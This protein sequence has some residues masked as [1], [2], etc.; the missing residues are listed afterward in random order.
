MLRQ[1]LWKLLLSL[2]IF[3]WAVAELIP[4]KDRP[5][6]QY[7]QSQ[8]QAYPVEFASLMKAAQAREKDQ[9]VQSVFV[10]LKELANEGKVDLSRFFPQIRLEASLKN[11]VKRNS[12]L[13]DELLRRSKGRLQLG[14]DL[15]GGVAFTLEVAPKSLADVPQAERQAKLTKAIEI[16][17]ARI[18]SLGVAEPIVRPVGNNR[19]EVQLP[20]VSTKDNP[21]IVSSLKKPARLDFRLV[22]TGGTPETIPPSDAPPGFEP[23]TL[24]Q[25]DN[26]GEIHT[27]ELYVKRIPEMTGSALSQAFASMDEFGRFK[28]LL[29]FTKEGGQRFAAVTRAIAE[30][31]Q[32]TGRIGQLAIVLDGKLYSAPTVREEIPSGSAEITGTFTQREAVELANVLNNPL[33]LPLDIKEQYEVGPSLAQDAI[34][35]GVKAAIIGT[36]LVAA[37]M[38]SYYTIGGLIASIAVSINVLIIMGTLASLG[39]TLSMPGIAGIV[40]TI[41]MAVDAHILIFERIR[42]E[43]ALGKSLKAALHAGHDKAFTTIVDAN[44][45]TMISSAL[46][47]ALGTG[48]VKG[49]GVTLTIGIFSTMFTALVVSR[50]LLEF[51]IEPE[52]I[53][54]FPM[55]SILRA[56][57]IDFVKYGKV[58]F[59]SSWLIVLVGVAS[60]VV[61]YKHIYGID[62]VG[63]DDATLTFVQRV[64]PERIRSALGAAKLG[65]VN[66]LYQSDL[67]GDH[68][69]LTVQTETGRGAEAVAVL[70]QAF[71]QAKFDA[72]GQTTIG[73]SIGKEI[74]W[75]AFMSLALSIVGI[76]IYVAFRFEI[77]Y[78]MGAVVSTVHDVLMTIGIFV[79]TGRQ[80]TAPMV[81]AILLIVGYSINDTIVVFDRIREELKTNPNGTLRDIINLATTKVFTRS[82]L[83]SLTTFLAALA[84]YLFGGGVINDLA[85]TFLVGIVTG[86][87]SSIFIASPIFYWWHKGDRKH[88]EAHHDIAPKYEW[89]GTS[90]ASQ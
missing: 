11:V 31:N 48:P 7:L 29:R 41:G 75:N 88:V 42:E 17:S 4:L 19:I 64:D 66:P 36:L 72:I 35:S 83:T 1:N 53:T 51:V 21:E 6:D 87:F 39:A 69:V 55:L 84:L 89:T 74:Q 63:G 16:I 90:R 13:L 56:A 73:P 71:P 46:M 30:E 40:L 67:A 25:E 27:S 65:E 58:C 43:L 15:K 34:D 70:Q 14:L 85:F 28:I 20:G 49:F 2:A 81:A 9:K 61:R 26:R 10:P 57:K 60:V 79:L 86:T 77:G 59:I 8:V 12:L 5:F 80:F 44:L 33:D 22:F 23:M 54:R 45:T 47:I 68:E 52:V 18:N 37:F 78:G 24:E 82:L 62:F 3:G 38:I 50:M 32:R 76:M